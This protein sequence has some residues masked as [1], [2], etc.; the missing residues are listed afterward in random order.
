[1]WAVPSLA[2]YL[3]DRLF[4]HAAPLLED[5]RGPV[6]PAATSGSPVADDFSDLFDAPT[7][8]RNPP[9]R[10]NFEDLLQPRREPAK[11]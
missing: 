8:G 5:E 3:P 2:T 7:P 10:D 1:V 9:Y 4:S 11:E 6:A